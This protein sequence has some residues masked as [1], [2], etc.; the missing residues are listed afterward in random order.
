MGNFWT[1]TGFEYKKLLQ[2]KVVWVTFIIMAVICVVTASIEYWGTSFSIDGKTVSG[3]EMTKRSIKQNKKQSGMK[4]DDSYLKKAKEEPGSLAYPVA[5]F[6]FVIT[7]LWGEEID[8][9]MADLYNTRKE[10]IE[11][12]WEEAHLTKGEMKYLADLEKEVEIP[13]VYEYSEGYERMNNMMSLVCMMQIMLV[14]VSI[15]AIMADE[16]K[17]KT[18]QI[19][20]CT[21]FGRKVL[22]LVKAFVGVT[23]SVVSMLLLSIVVAIPI[24]AVYGFGGF[25]ASIQQ[26][27]PMQSWLMTLGEKCLIIIAVNLISSVLHCSL[28]MMLAE[29]ARSTVAPMAILIGVMLI[30]VFLNIP[31]QYRILVQT[32]DCIPGNILTSGGPFGVRLFSIFGHYFTQWQMIPIIWL[33]ISAAALLSGYRL[34]KNYQVAGR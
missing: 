25:T 2:K 1:M 9:N 10:L 18:D 15:P 26:Y 34:Y 12:K 30:S 20:L 19:I 7:G 13:V 8:V 17:G 16:H 27:V 32:W 4:I 23:F 11:R 6:I 33:L 22:Y 5:N 21:H 29:K 3:Y 31:E 24:F 14:A 28:G